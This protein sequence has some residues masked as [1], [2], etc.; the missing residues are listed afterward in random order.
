MLS[1]RMLHSLLASSA[2]ACVIVVFTFFAVE[3]MC[4]LREEYLMQSIII[5]KDK[6]FLAKCQTPEGYANMNHHPNFC[7][8]IIATARTGA[9]WHAVKKVASSLPLDQMG[10][11]IEKIG[12]RVCLAGGLLFLIM[13]SI[14]LRNSRTNREFIPYYSKNENF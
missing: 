7:E 10:L 4:L 14:F 8:K 2:S 3:K 1:N 5:E 11:N 12:W 9:F 6:D 13:P